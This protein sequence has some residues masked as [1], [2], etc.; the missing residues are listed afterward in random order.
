MC[1]PPFQWRLVDLTE[2]PIL[3]GANDSE[4]VL[5]QWGYESFRIFLL[6]RARSS[7]RKQNQSETPPVDSE[8]AISTGPPHLT[9]LFEPKRH[10]IP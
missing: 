4:I 5:S 10:V 9:F 1:I 8:V 2:S 3:A 6:D 7:V